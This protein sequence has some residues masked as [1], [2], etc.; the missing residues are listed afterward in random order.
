METSW[1][2]R[3]RSL[4]AALVQHGNLAGKNVGKKNDIGDGIMLSAQEWQ[5]LEHILEYHDETCNMVTMSNRLGVPQSS[6]SRAVKVLCSAGLVDKYQAVNNRKNIILKPTEYGCRLYERNAARLLQEQFR[7]F[8][9][10]LE[11]ISDEDLNTVIR[12][13]EYLNVSMD[14]DLQAG[15]SPQLIKIEQQK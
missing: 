2:G 5:I 11:P 8:F 6:F 7:P 12:A 1:M 13:I 14:P 15:A 10:M 3:Y 4:V 9:D